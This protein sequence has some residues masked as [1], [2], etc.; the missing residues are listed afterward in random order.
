MGGGAGVAFGGTFKIATERTV[1]SM[2]ECGIGFFTD[3][4][5]LF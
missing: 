2:P 5:L 3:V 1:F 4:R